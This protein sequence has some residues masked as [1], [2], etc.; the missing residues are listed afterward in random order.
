MKIILKQVWSAR[1]I[2]SDIK[3]E[4]KNDKIYAMKIMKKIEFLIKI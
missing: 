3:D 2:K 1:Y 4:K